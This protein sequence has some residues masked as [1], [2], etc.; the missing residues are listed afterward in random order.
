VRGN[1]IDDTHK[2]GIMVSAS[3]HVTVIDNQLS[4]DN[5]GFIGNEPNR[6]KGREG[7]RTLDYLT[8]TNNVVADSGLSEV[9]QL[10][11]GSVVEIKHNKYEH[12]A[13]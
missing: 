11:A 5:E 9:V 6:G 1:R 2:A 13:H 10:P 4:H 3:N 12:S 8:V 7:P